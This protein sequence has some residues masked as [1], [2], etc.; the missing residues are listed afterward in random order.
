MKKLLSFLGTTNYTSC[1]YYY[2]EHTATY[3]RFIQTAVYEV[4][5]AEG[6]KMDEVIVLPTEKAI[7]KNWNDTSETV[8]L[9]TTWDDKFPD[10]K[11]ILKSI[12]ISDQ[13]ME[14]AQW[15]LFDII[16]D[17]IDEGDEIYFDITHGFRSHPF[18]ALLIVNFSRLIKNAQL[19]G[20]FYGNF[21]SLLGRGYEVKEMESEERFAPIID[22]TEMLRL[23]DWTNGVN[24]FLQT[25]NAKM[26][27]EMAGEDVRQNQNSLPFKKISNS[28]LNMSEVIETCRGMEIDEKVIQA[29]DQVKNEKSNLSENQPLYSKLVDTIEEK[30]NG[31]NRNHYILNIPESVDWCVEHGLY[32]QAYTILEEGTISTVCMLGDMQKDDRSQR[33]IASSALHLYKKHECEWDDFA[34]KNSSKVNELTEK[35]GKYQKNLRWYDGVNEKRNDINHNGMNSHAMRVNRLVESLKKMVQKSRPFFRAVYDDYFAQQGER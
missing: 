6:H 23:L 3:S 10:K 13:Q 17:Q 29:I 35:L 25:G 9:K 15:I 11:E 24:A 2:K 21:E 34:K 26:I 7:S 5:E 27:K 4:L 16:F 30:L 32:Q 20:L 28:L 22:M 8:G 31:F 18:I 19:G 33:R 14:E 12:T 1:Y